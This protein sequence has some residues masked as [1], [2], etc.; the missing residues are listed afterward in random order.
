MASWSRLIA[1]SEEIGDSMAGRKGRDVE[2][3]R[4]QKITHIGG[5]LLFHQC[6]GRSD[7]D[8]DHHD[9]SGET[10]AAAE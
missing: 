10:K 6:F 5:H 7:G 9:E 1:L 4:T 2:V 3:N 8:G